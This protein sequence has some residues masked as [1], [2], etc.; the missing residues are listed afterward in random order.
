MPGFSFYARMGRLSSIIF[1]LPCSMAAGWIA[2]HY[3]VDRYFS[4]YPWGSL[5][6]ILLGAGAGLYEILRL[7][8]TGQRKKRDQP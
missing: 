2:G 8:E 7:L 3:I 5:S 1:I 4:I 6:F